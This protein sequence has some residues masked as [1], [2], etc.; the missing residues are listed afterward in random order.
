MNRKEDGALEI[1]KKARKKVFHEFH[2]FKRK[3]YRSFNFEEQWNA[4]RKIQFYSI[5]KEYFEF[6][7]T[8]PEG[9]LAL[10]IKEKRPILA[11]WETYLKDMRLQCNTWE[12]IDELL[13]IMLLG[14]RLP[15]A[16]KEA[17]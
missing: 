10:V 12:D 8:I 7:E 13:E 17:A 6:N 2:V 3:V 15:V 4:C 14:W 5:V 9:Y 1:R 16:E 11:M